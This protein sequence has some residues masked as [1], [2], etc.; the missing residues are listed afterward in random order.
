MG[1]A[2]MDKKYV[3]VMALALIAYLPLTF[4]GFGSDL[5]SSYVYTTSQHL[6]KYHQYIP[7]RSPGYF[8]HEALSSF[9]IYFAGSL[10]SNIGTLFMSLITIYCFLK[11]CDYY[12]IKNNMLLSL[13]IILHPV[14][15]VNSTSTIDYIWAIG[16]FFIGYY[17]FLI[18]KA[19]ISIFFFSLAIGCRLSSI[20]LIAIICLVY[21]KDMKRSILLLL[22]SSLAGS[23]FYLPSFFAAGNKFGFLTFSTGDWTPYEFLVRF[24]YKN[25]YFWGLLA[26][27]FT[28][29]LIINLKKIKLTYSNHRDPIIISLLV[30]VSYELLFL[31]VPLEL[32]YLLPIL[33]FVFICLGIFFEKQKMLII[34]FIIL[35]F[36]YSIIS[37]NF[38]KYNDKKNAKNVLDVKNGLA[39]FLLEPGY[40]I[41]DINSRILA[42]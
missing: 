34:I 36:S 13:G 17:C 15:W 9:L 33:P 28:P 11:I 19:P 18:K 12:K 4:L 8:V 30:L 29:A 24:I 38:I 7:S 31:K 10:G 27:F 20:I 23:V 1:Q 6:L 25:I 21:P 16:F 32:G 39:T 40:L 41:K 37:L 26:T 42:K 5:D 22:T 35:I 14:Y 2:I 3:V